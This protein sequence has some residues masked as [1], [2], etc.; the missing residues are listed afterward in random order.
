MKKEYLIPVTILGAF[1]LGLIAWFASDGNPACVWMLGALVFAGDHLGVWVLGLLTVALLSGV[2]IIL[3]AALLAALTKSNVK[4]FGLFI[5]FVIAF[6]G[7][8]FFVIEINPGIGWKYVK[9]FHRY[10][11]PAI[12][13]FR[14]SIL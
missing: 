7:L 6:W 12:Q 3:P 11:L 4:P 13:T 2:M 9:F 14:D 8:V 5:L 10:L 1:F